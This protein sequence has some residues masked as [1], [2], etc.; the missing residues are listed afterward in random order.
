MFSKKITITFI[1]LLIIVS[2]VLSMVSIGRTAP[3]TPIAKPT[4]KATCISEEGKEFI[5]GFENTILYPYDDTGRKPRRLTE[6]NKNAAIGVGHLIQKSEW[7]TYKNGITREEAD[8]LFEAD[9]NRFSQQ[10][11][12]LIKVDLTQQQYDAIISFSYNIGAGAFKN[13]TALKYINDP[14]YTSDKY[15]SLADAWKAFNKQ[16]DVVLEGLN[17]RR[18]AELAVYYN[19]DYSGRP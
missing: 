17:K 4:A 19:G 14:E 16:R 9:L 2:V 8:Q 5:R 18:A 12:P 3:A 7:D 13:S 6:W 1:C 11:A 10:I 15:K